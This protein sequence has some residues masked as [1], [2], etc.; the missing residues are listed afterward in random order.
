MYLLTLG[1]TFPL[2]PP[3][4]WALAKVNIALPPHL[5]RKEHCWEGHCYLCHCYGKAENLQK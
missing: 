2:N 4:L 5:S 3:S 1:L